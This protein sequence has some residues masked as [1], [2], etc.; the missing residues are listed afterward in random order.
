[1]YV[2]VSSLFCYVSQNFY[3]VHILAGVQSL[4]HSPLVQA[5]AEGLRRLLAI[6]VQKKTPVSV[7]ILSEIVKDAEAHSCLSNIWFAI[8]CLLAFSSFLWFFEL[9]QLQ[10]SDITITDEIMTVK[11]QGSKTDQLRQGD[12]VLTARTPNSTCPVAMLE[13][14]KRVADIDQHSDLLLFRVIMY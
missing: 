7:G 1:M 5:T 9:I 12:E 4:T 13:W 11:I 3:Q 6:P 10:P 8:V 14:Y 2:Y